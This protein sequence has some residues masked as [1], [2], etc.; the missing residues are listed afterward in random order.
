MLTLLASSLAVTCSG[1]RDYMGVVGEPIQGGRRQQRITEDLGPFLGR[2]ITGQ[3]DGSLFVALANDFV[4][5][6]GFVCLERSQA[7][8][9]D[10]H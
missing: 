7:K 4:E 3:Q 2:P 8:I 1:Q 10:D 5:V 6:V 9:V